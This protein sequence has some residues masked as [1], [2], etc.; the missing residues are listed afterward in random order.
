[1]SDKKRIIAKILQIDAIFFHYLLQ[2]DL[3]CQHNFL[4]NQ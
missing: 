1:M 2:C 3:H 4:N